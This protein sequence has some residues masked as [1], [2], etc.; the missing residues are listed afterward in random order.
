M[1]LIILAFQISGVFTVFA[2]GLRGNRDELLYLF[3]RPRELVVSLLAMFVV[4]PFFAFVVIDVFNLGLLASVAIVSM[5]LLPALATVPGAQRKAGG[6]YQYAIGLAFASV[7]LSIV[8]SP[9]LVVFLGDLA[10]NP[11]DLSFERGLLAYVFPLVLLPLLAGLLVQRALPRAAERL[12]KPLVRAADLLVKGL[13]IVLAV[14]ALLLAWNALGVRTVLGLTVFAVLGLAIGHVM[15]GPEQDKSI[16]LAYSC[17]GANRTIWIAL[18]IAE[19]N[20]NE[21]VGGVIILFVL[22]SV[23][24]SNL[25]LRLLRRTRPAPAVA[26]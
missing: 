25:Y 22:I 26:T 5:S 24:V 15:G 1:G 20:F 3:R 7:V 12:G 16:V 14:P 23:V 11:F 18:T 4:T 10:G 2:Y 17:S 21:D 19:I 13:L 6:H 9:A 8:I